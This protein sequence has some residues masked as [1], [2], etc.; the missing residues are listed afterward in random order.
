[1]GGKLTMKIHKLIT[2]TLI[3][4]FGILNLAGCSSVMSTRI[5]ERG[6]TMKQAYNEAINGTSGKN[7]NT[8]K[9]MRVTVL[10]HVEGI[11]SYAAYTRTQENEIDAQF[12]KL[13]NPSIVMYVYPHE[14]GSVYNLVPVPGYSTVFP[15]YTHVYYAMPGENPL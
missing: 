15:M 11:P 3:S 4:F 1:M 6:I 10:E 9:K 14:T 2:V 5:S 12:Q 7:L 13:S 8:L